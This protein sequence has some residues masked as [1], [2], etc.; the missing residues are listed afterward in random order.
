VKGIQDWSHAMKKTLIYFILALFLEI[1]LSALFFYTYNSIPTTN[2]QKDKQ[3]TI[4]LINLQNNS[5]TKCIADT[6]TGSRGLKKQKSL[7]KLKSKK[8]V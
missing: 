1:G 8:C 3:N 7:R 2:T 4:S 5:D 6:G